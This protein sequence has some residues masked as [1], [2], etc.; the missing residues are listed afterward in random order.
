M[1]GHRI[2]L[3]SWLTLRPRKGTIAVGCRAAMV[4]FDPDAVISDRTRYLNADHIRHGGASA[5][6][7]FEIV[8]ADGQCLSR[9][10]SAPGFPQPADPTA[11]L[12][13]SR[14]NGCPSGRK[15]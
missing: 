15:P 11:Q 5:E 7:V 6:D 1:F 14:R 10:E 4:E 3:E 8:I 13:M 12:A 9:T 2:P